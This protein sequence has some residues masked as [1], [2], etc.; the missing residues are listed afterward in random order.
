MNA[1]LEWFDPQQG[2][3]EGLADQYAQLI[4]HGLLSEGAK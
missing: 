1:S 4:L 3:I 2:N